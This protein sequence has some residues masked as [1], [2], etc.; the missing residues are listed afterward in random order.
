MFNPSLPRENI[1]AQAASTDGR[2]TLYANGQ[3]HMFERK[4][5][6]KKQRGGFKYKKNK[7]IYFLLFLPKAVFEH[8][9]I[10]TRVMNFFFFSSINL[11]FIFRCSSAPSNPVYVRCVDSSDLVFSLSSYRHSEIGLNF[12]S[13]FIDSQYTVT[14]TTIFYMVEETALGSRFIV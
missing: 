12:S 7:T 13:C 1:D 14:Y 8:V 6:I 4:V 5:V 3:M 9:Y 11:V 10:S 2:A